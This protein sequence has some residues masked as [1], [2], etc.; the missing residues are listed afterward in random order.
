MG[1]LD[2]QIRFAPGLLLH[3]LSGSLGGDERRTEERLE[4]AMLRSF[5]VKLLQAIREAVALARDSTEALGDLIEEFIDCSTP[6]PTEPRP[7]ADRRS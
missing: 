6:I 2:D 5:G 4:L 3:V 7:P 1:L